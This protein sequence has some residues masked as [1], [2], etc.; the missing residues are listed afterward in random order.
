MHHSYRTS[1]ICSSEI[2]FDLE[3]NI[4]R[5]VEFCGGCHGNLQAIVK[6]AEGCTVEEIEQ[7]CSGILCGRK[8]SSCPDQLSRAVRKAYEQEQKA[9]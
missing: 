1:G 2:K 3:G 7:K 9:Q 5:N 8:S 4:V 6:F